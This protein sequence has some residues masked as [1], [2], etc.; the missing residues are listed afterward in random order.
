MTHSFSEKIPIL[1][2]V[3]ERIYTLNEIIKHFISN[4]SNNKI[5]IIK[6]ATLHWT[7]SSGKMCYNIKIQI[8]EA[9]RRKPGRQAGC[10]WRAQASV[11]LWHAG[12]VCSFPSQLCSKL[13]SGARCAPPHQ[14][15][16]SQSRRQQSRH[17]EPVIC[18]LHGLAASS[19][20]RT[21]ET[22]PSVSQ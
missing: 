20:P 13:C 8:N 16:T 6:F 2:R 14:P 19:L 12:M 3:I 7:T 4:Q 22:P 11:V 1:H 9:K 10:W 17:N 15:T 21:G 18:D 5:D